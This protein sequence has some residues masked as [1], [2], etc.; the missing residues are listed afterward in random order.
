MAYKYVYIT[1]M[2]LYLSL[3]MFIASDLGLSYEGLE[4]VTDEHTGRT[5]GALVA[6]MRSFWSIITFRVD[7]MP[8]W[9]PLFFIYPVVVGFLAI[10]IDVIKDVIPFT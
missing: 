10:I 6:M 9:F 2:V 4:I 7:G 1:I 8:V 5:F 3:I